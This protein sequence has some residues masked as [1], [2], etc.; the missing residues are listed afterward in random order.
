MPRTPDDLKIKT[1]TFSALGEAPEI[2]PRAERDARLSVRLLVALAL[3]AFL[4]RLVNLGSFSLWFDEVAET[5][6]AGGSLARTWAELQSDV[7]HPPL[8]GLLTWSLLHLGLGEIARRCVPITFGVLTVLLLAS[9]TA[10]RFGRTAGIAAGL[11]AAG[12]PLHVHYSQE[13]RPYSLALLCVALAVLAADRALARVGWRRLGL[14]ALAILGCLYSLY[15]AA[16]VTLTFA[17]WLIVDTALTG[18]SEEAGRAR[19]ILAR[20]P[21]LLLGLGLAY[22]PWLSTVFGLRQRRI[23]QAASHWTW[24]SVTERWQALTVGSGTSGSVWGSAVALLLVLLGSARAVRTPAGR[25]VLAA[26]LCGTVGID[27]LLLRI[28]HWS[29]VRYNLMGWLFL[30]ALAGM[31]ADVLVRLRRSRA[32]AAAALF[33]LA[34]AQAQGIV[35]DHHLRHDWRRVAEVVDELWRSGEPVLALN[36]STR[37]PLLYYLREMHSPAAAAV[38]SVDGSHR[39][40]ASLWP[41][42]RCALLVLRSNGRTGRVVRLTQGA[43]ELARYPACS[44]ARLRLLTPRFR[45]QLFRQLGGERS[46]GPAAPQALALHCERGLSPELLTSRADRP[47]DPLLRLLGLHTEGATFH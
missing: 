19:R 40:L 2:S 18:S 41:G 4:P 13:L 38:I 45:D 14:T 1:I 42:D 43:D 33:F 24:E 27:L 17:G 32:V 3:L 29:N 8:E 10:R 20:S 23:E 11:F 30:A 5:L 7:V 36:Q 28:D 15:F 25:A 44:G 39:R 37:I 34:C 26:A 35:R 46:L 21:F 22:L 12:A 31:G 6:Q 47:Y 9:W 16:L